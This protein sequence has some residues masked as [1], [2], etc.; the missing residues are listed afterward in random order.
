M[1]I[2]IADDHTLFRDALTLYINQ[3]EPSYNLTVARDVKEVMDILSENASFDLLLLDYR[4]PGMNGFQGLRKIRQTWPDLRVALMSG[5]ANE[6]E[7]RMSLELGAVG[8]FPKTMPGHA[9]VKG[10]QKIMDG[11]QFIP[12]DHNTN[13]LMPSFEPTFQPS[14]D[15]AANQD[16]SGDSVHLTARELDVLEHLLQGHSNKLIASALGLQVVTVKLHVRSL[17]KK[18]GAQN[19][20]QVALKAREMGILDQFLRPSSHQD[21]TTKPISKRT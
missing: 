17:C 8:Y 5:I 13:R 2:L 6:E 15:K 14:P 12:L 4:M 9:M 16:G 1:K 3:I 18:L 19:R 21:P 7:V 10:F 20:T 11:E